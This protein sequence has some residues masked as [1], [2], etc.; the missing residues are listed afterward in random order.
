[1]RGQ[2]DDERDAALRQQEAAEAEAERLLSELTEREQTITRLNRAVAQEQRERHVQSS[3]AV[4]DYENLRTR[5]IRSI[6]RQLGL[7]EDGLHALRNGST[8]VTEEYLERVIEAFVSQANSLREANS[9]EEG[10]R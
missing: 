5:V 4:D 3:H 7:L 9:P 8:G 6:D 1:L 2:A 10:T